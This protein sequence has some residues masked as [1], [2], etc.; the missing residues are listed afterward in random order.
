M[1]SIDLFLAKCRRNLSTKQILL[2]L[3]NQLGVT[4]CSHCDLNVKCM[5]LKIQVSMMVRGLKCTLW[6]F[7]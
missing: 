5:N 7:Y 4:Q 2:D 1:V 6:I 3:L